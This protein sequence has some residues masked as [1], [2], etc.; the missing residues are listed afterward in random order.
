LNVAHKTDDRELSALLS[1]EPSTQGVLSR[2]QRSSGRLREHGNI[3][4]GDIVP[5]EPPSAEEAHANGFKVAW[6]H[7]EDVN[8]PLIASDHDGL[9]SPESI[10]R[11]RPSGADC[12]HVATKRQSFDRPPVEISNVWHRDRIR[13][14]VDGK[15]ILRLETER[16]AE[17]RHERASRNYRT[18]DKHDR[19][20][21][22][23]CDQ[24]TAC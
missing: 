24:M 16:D 21:N 23:H 20:R 2:E 4:T 5:P 3:A 18:E 12:H 13:L 10:C 19:Q 14:H 17:H 9:G 8:R 22:L 11:N 1:R 7:V 15:K 6:Q